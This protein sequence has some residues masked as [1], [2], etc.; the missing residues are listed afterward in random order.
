M[1]FSRAYSSTL[2]LSSSI[3]VHCNEQ[4]SDDCTIA[5][6]L[7]ITSSAT[8]NFIEAG[9]WSNIT[10]VRNKQAV[11][12]YLIPYGIF[13]FFKK[14][15]NLQWSTGVLAIS[16]D[17]FK[18]ADE[19]KKLNLDDNQIQTLPS[20]VF[21]NAKHLQDIQLSRNNI[22]LIEDD[23]FSGLTHLQSLLLN[24]NSL[25]IIKANTFVRIVNLIK[26]ELNFNQIETIED[27]AF[28]ISTLQHLQLA[29]NRLRSIPENLFASASN[30]AI[31]SIGYNFLSRIGQ[32][33]H[34]LKNMYGLELTANEIRDIKL[35]EFAKL[36][37][38]TVLGL[39]SSGFT[40]NNLGEWPNK[41][42]S[43]AHLDLAM[44]E[45]YHSNIL[46]LLRPLANLETLHL[47]EN[48]FL[49]IN[50]I[51]DIKK[52][53][54]NLRTMGITANRFDREQLQQYIESLRNQKVY[55][56]TEAANTL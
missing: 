29:H 22:N 28:N 19:L 35:N 46:D 26:L 38:L 25:T 32:T 11:G 51:N 50:E 13:Q 48:D 14:L 37:K 40:F 15:E 21:E 7:N 45:L 2:S 43:I 47:E 24:Q 1:L 55:L 3:H 54:P 5:E 16:K 8:L 52:I 18:D 44:N 30:L 6:F 20:N 42:S 41:T 31:V 9:R 4:R 23:A 49:E 12:A 56:P 17:T 36:P 10:E 27:G 34:G 33:F 53:F 39:R